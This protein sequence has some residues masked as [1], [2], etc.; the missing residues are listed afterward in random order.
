MGYLS[1][2]IIK[3]NGQRV[4][5]P[6]LRNEFQVE[7]L[8]IL[9]RPKYVTFGFRTN[10]LQKEFKQIPK[11]AKIRYELNKLKEQ[12]LI[13]KMEKSNYY[14]VTKLGWVWLWSILLQKDFFL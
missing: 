6:D 1:K 13:K 5:A 7:L 12:G 2:P 4:A 10:D 3:E 8:R 9:L 11:T 14:A